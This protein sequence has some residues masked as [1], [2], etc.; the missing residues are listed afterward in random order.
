MITL[1]YLISKFL[2]STSNVLILG[3]TGTGKD[4]IARAL[5]YNS[6]TYNPAEFRYVSV[7]IAAIPPSLVE[8]ELFGYVRGA[9]TDAR[10][11]GN[12]GKFELAKD[13]V[14]HL[15]EVGDVPL[16]LQP[17]LLSVIQ[18]RTVTRLGANMPIGL[19]D[20][21]FVASTHKDLT[22]LVREGRFR[23]DFFYRLN[24]SVL[25]SPS[26]SERGQ[27]ET[28]LLVNYFLKRASHR[29]DVAI[30]PKALESLSSF[31]LIGNVR[32]LENLVIRA[33]DLAGGGIIQDKHIRMS[34]FYEMAAYRGIVSPNTPLSDIPKFGEAAAETGII[35]ELAMNPNALEFVE[36][37]HISGV[38]RKL[39]GNKEAVALALGISRRALYR[40]LEKYDMDD[41]IRRRKSHEKVV[42]EPEAETPTP[43]ITN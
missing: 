27:E 22:Q 33:N 23:E 42:P 10:R 13:G 31:A 26:M 9:F 14:I 20:I 15:D 2:S 41:V 6:S 39:G 34:I 28:E 3:E 25:Y 4:L 30:S 19:G 11:D 40:K 21:R 24:Q 38:L 12:P 29:Q 35:E 8:S 32:S 5:Y 1:F 17:K 36:R 37:E 16:E 18:S 7:N 43:I